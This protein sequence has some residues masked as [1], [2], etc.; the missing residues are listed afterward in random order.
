VTDDSWEW[1][2]D[3][4]DQG[5]L[6]QWA[7]PD[8]YG[9]PSNTFGFVPEEFYAIVGHVVMLAA[10]VELQLLRLV[11]V[12]DRSEPQETYAGMPGAQLIHLLRR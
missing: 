1:W 6:D 4:D 5:A 3:P 8:D 9:V 12:F 11:W 2:A 10:L 7:K